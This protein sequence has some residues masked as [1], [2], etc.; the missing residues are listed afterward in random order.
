MEDK[1]ANVGTAINFVNSIAE[2][3]VFLVFFLS[4]EFIQRV[5]K[6]KKKKKDKKENRIL[7]LK[8]LWTKTPHMS[9]W[10]VLLVG[11]STIILK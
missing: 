9:S 2:M 3:R 11:V 5:T 6:K 10:C 1:S 7:F 8:N 4:E